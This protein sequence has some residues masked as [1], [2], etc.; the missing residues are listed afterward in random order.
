[1]IGT[2]PGTEEIVNRSVQ[3][4]KKAMA[5]QAVVHVGRGSRNGKVT[6]YVQK[7]TGAMTKFEID[8]PGVLGSRMLTWHDGLN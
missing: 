8:V 5:S 6:A 3:T 4:S 2:T 7:S 1:M